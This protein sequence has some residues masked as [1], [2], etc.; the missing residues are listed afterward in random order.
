VIETQRPE[1]WA[2]YQPGFR[3][4]RHPV[5][6]APFFAEVEAH[7]YALEPHIREIVRFERW[8]GSDVLEA[9]CG[10]ATDG[11]AFARAGARYTGVDQSETALT[12]AS[13]R[14]EAEKLEG[15]F[16]RASVTALPF[17][18]STFDLVYSH[19]VIHHV[20]DTQRAVDEFRRVLRPGGTALVMVYHRDSLNYR[21][22]IMVIRRALGALLAVPG[23]AAAIASVTGEPR[24][25]LE[26]HRRLLHEHGVAYLTDRQLFLSNNTDGPGNPL[27]KVFSRAEARALFAGFDRIQV[28]VR[29][30]N[31]RL[32][33]GGDRL[34][35]TETARRLE[36][37]WGWHL[38][39]K[40]VKPPH[41]R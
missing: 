34:A 35:A 20:A 25:V 6:T 31:L 38:Y 36:R 37:R 17:A 29:Y 19:G 3:F 33:P 39:L 12:L 1:F 15:R 27:S 14:F 18:D 9:G 2:A 5:G 26:G 8:T 16:E 21:F 7:R 11:V 41:G 30:L 4:S 23:S 40:G 10:I 13:R 32:F 22:N 24:E 28:A